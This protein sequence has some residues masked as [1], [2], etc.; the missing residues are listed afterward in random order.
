MR[1]LMLLLLVCIPLSSFSQQ[2][3]AG[4]D[5]DEYLSLL[6]LPQQNDSS[7]QAF[8]SKDFKLLYVSPEV[9]LFNKWFLWKRSDGVGV[10]VIRGTVGRMESWLANFYAAMI[11]AKGSMQLNDS[12]RFD[13]QLAADTAKA[14]V[15]VGWTISLGHMAPTMV[16]KI[17][18]LY[19]QGSR[20]FIIMGHSQ[21]GAIAFL[22]RSYFEYN[23]ELP[24]DIVYKTYCS[25]APKPG[26]LFYAYD[27]DFITRLGW[28]FR[29]VNSEDW[30]PETPFSLQT[31]K[32]FNDVNA[33]MNVPGMLKK[34][35]FFVRVYGK[36]VYNKLNR[37]SQKSMKRFRRTLGKRVGMLVK[38]T[39]KQ[40][41]TPPYTYSNNYMTA[42]T[43][44]ILLADSTYHTKYKF[45]GKN[46]FVHHM[47][48][49]Y[50]DLLTRRY[51]LK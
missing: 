43:P 22:T 26:N 48:E 31:L 3:K 41:Q 4:F 2:L 42:G 16:R 50:I 24:K 47:F 35:K 38:R 40:L 5:A 27:F 15:H 36:S 51:G 44:V 46:V 18:E 37:V 8:T 7:A 11:P 45:D 32:D 1:Q 23:P 10:I 49:P 28:G 30:V 12:T 6:K 33:F 21:G 9:G 20:Q 34:Q 13:Y 25:A 29:V 14:Y 39:L 17:K 19:A